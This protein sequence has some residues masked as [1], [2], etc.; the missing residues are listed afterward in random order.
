M[1]YERT[2]PSLA[3]VYRIG[4]N[5]SNAKYG[6]AQQVSQRPV[7]LRPHSGHGPFGFA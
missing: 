4:R 7:E 5:K 2:N 3:S 6:R 1:G